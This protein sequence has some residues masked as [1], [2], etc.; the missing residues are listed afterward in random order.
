MPNLPESKP[1]LVSLTSFGQSVL[2]FPEKLLDSLHD[3]VYFVDRD[4]RIQYWNK[5]AER[6]TGFPA[7]EVV[8][9]LCRD[10]ILMH[11]N[12]AG[13][14]LCVTGCPLVETLFD[15]QRR[16]HELYLRHK[17]GHRV[18]VSVRVAPIVNSEGDIVG[19]IEVFSDITA[20]RNME[21]RVG[22]L[23]SL[24]FLDPLTGI[25][26]RR[27]IELKVRQAIED[28]QEVGRNAALL[29]IDVDNFKQINDK[30]GHEAGDTVLRTVCK[31]LA[32]NLRAGD[33]L[34]RW[35]GDELLLIGRDFNGQTLEKFARKC[36]MLV[37]E[38]AIPSG[39]KHI[40]VTASVGATLMKPGDTEQSAI[41]RADELMYKS[42]AA[43]RH[44][45]HV[46]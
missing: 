20:V 42:K 29:L 32:N 14:T 13:C 4:R 44:R 2:S 26:N 36:C 10:N 5:G 41:Q 31:T 15:G 23:E 40:R 43:G 35:G 27:Y 30:H 38:S 34:G 37:A 21:R 1:T 3:G 7:D 6:L 22:E 11:V 18:P 25:P 8:G 28:N 19:A 39:G 17:L 45:V 12:A 24:A 46:G 33:I 16:E 9:R